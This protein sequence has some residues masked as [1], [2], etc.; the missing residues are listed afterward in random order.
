MSA[1]RLVVSA[2]IALALSACQR[3]TN[4]GAERDAGGTAKTVHEVTAVQPEDAGA[5]AVA[6]DAGAENAAD[7]GQAMGETAK[8]EARVY[9][10]RDN[11]M[12]C[13]AAP[14]MNLDVLPV[15]SSE[16][17]QK[18]S[19][20]DLSAL[21]LSPDGTAAVMAAVHGKTGI[22]VEGEV[23]DGPRGKA[24]VSRVV[25]VTRLVDAKLP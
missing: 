9:L 17:T 2:V 18:A 5:M 7:A 21:N 12:R 13:I 25:R 14:C 15:N 3:H 10:V 11:K 19:D 16:P 22:R 23:V 1:R 20:L 4:E 6:E 8:P 24:G